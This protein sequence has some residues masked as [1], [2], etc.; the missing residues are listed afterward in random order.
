MNK[1]I[2]PCWSAKKTD[3][4][5]KG[6]PQADSSSEIPVESLLYYP[7]LWTVGNHCISVWGVLQSGAQT[8]ARK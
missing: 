5:S 6:M 1:G 4:V 7:L 2:T 3:R 8:P